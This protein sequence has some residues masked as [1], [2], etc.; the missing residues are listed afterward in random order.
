MQ[1]KSLDL[2]CPCEGEAQ[3]WVRGIRTLKERVG[4]MSQK[5]K[6]DQYPFMS[7]V[8]LFDQPWSAL[9]GRLMVSMAMITPMSTNINTGEICIPIMAMMTHPNTS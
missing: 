3:S 9:R 2:L 1:Y 6:L 7:V 4:N 5:E 8:L